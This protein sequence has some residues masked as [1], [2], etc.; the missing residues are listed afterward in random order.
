MKLIFLVLF[1]YID[2]I[3]KYIDYIFS[4]IFFDISPFLFKQNIK[5]QFFTME[6]M[7]FLC[8]KL[9]VY[10][11]NNLLLTI[12]KCFYIFLDRINSEIYLRIYFFKTCF[13]EFLISVVYIGRGGIVFC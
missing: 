7:N 4:N 9:F 10:L 1:S 5:R 11:I 12:V 8:L 3:N 13:I 2:V 6:N